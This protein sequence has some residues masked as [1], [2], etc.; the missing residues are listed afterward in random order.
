MKKIIA[1]LLICSLLLPCVSCAIKSSASEL[2]A[3]YERKTTESGE[4]TEEFKKAMADFSLKMLK[5]LL[6]KD[7]KNDLVSPLS[8]IICLAMIANGADGNTKAQTEAALGIDVDS[9]NKALYTYTSS[10]YSS[11]ECRINIADSI[12]FRDDGTL[13]VNEDF[14]QTNADWFDAQ[15]FASPF[16]NST[17]NDIN[18]WC[19][20]HTD[21]MIK[22]MIDKIDD[23]TLMYLINALSFDAKWEKQYESDQVVER[24]FNNYDGTSKKIEMLTSSESCYISSDGV[25]GFAKNYKGNA[26]SFVA[27]LPDEGADI[28]D[29]IDSLDGS[30]WLDLW[31][32][33]QSCA[34]DVTMPEFTYDT[35]MNMNDLLKNMGMTDMFD[36]ALA[37]FS[38]IGKSALGNIFCSEVCQKTFIQVDRNG[39]K[40]A[41]ITWGAMKPESDEPISKNI[42]ILDRPFVYAIVDNATG[43]PVFIGAVTNL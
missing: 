19:D 6:T 8:A 4:I 33:K 14:L 1:L 21:G 23:D 10:L 37:D 35:E 11:G 5:G 39:T 22:K 27:L 18:H 12:W 41:A 30:L 36:S 34:V 31:N 43:L 2:S 3:G 40:A 42:V 32:G 29:Y 7:E 24:K 13:N 25:I 28:Y 26:Y 38:K 20:K 17:V 16:D 15:V 9:L